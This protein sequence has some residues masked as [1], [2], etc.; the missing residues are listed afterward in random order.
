MGKDK[1]RKSR[2]LEIDRRLMKIYPEAKT[3]LHYSNPLELLIATI[4]SAQCADEKVNQV[5]P[6]LF[7]EYRTARDYADAPLNELEGMIRPT[8]FF[9][10][11]AKSIQGCCKTLVKNFAG[12]IP[13]TMEEMVTL[14]GV[15]RKTANLVLGAVYGIPGIVVDTHVRRLS[16]RLDL[17]DNADPDKIEFDLMPLIPKDRWTP[18]SHQLVY[19]GRNT[20]FARKPNCS[21]CILRDL[22]PFPDHSE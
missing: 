8:G 2:A 11:K 12:K 7:G 19:H 3:A 4:L 16:G 22:C 6:A 1:D 9:R 21:E 5:T 14:P 20:C 13:E 18:F 15:G 17:S 10:N